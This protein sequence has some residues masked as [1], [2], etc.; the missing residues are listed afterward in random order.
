MA[1]AFEGEFL[2]DDRQITAAARYD[3]TE[4]DHSST[5]ERVLG[6][7]ES[8]ARKTR[9][10]NTLQMQLEFEPAIREDVDVI[11]L[12][13]NS[14]QA[15][16]IRPQLRFLDAGGIPVYST[17]RVFSGEP[18][19]AG[20]QDLDGLRFPA[21]PWELGHTSEESIP[22]LASLRG[23][24]LGALF[25]VGQDAW[26]VLPWLDLMRRDGDFAFPGASGSYRMGRDGGLVR[27]PAWAEFRGGVPRPLPPPAIPA[28]EPPARPGR[29]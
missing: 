13:A 11:F 27:E 29:L 17:G 8:K 24:V 2:Q 26:N 6:I 3:Q 12:A 1:V 25:A 28:N 21:L 16:L 19:P 4:N 9:L 20:N 10:E 23:G 5:L 18:D 7:D 22:D 15:R 14:M